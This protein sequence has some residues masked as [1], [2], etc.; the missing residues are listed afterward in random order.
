MKLVNQQNVGSL[1]NIEEREVHIIKFEGSNDKPKVLARMYGSASDRRGLGD[2]V[3][4]N[5]VLKHIKHYHPDWEVYVE[6]SRGKDSCHTGFCK[7][8]FCVEDRNTPVFDT[9][10]N[11]PFEEPN[12]QT[13]D[14]SLEHNVPAS[15]PTSA[16]KKVL[17]Q[18]PIKE[19]FKYQIN[20][21]EN[22][23]RRARKYMES[24][25]QKN[26]IVILHYQACSS[27]NNK[28][29]D[30]HDAERICKSLL[31]NGYTP[32]IF[33]WFG[34]SPLPDNKKIFCPSKGHP[35]WGE[36]KNNGEAKM[37]AALIEQARLFVGV[38]SGPLHVAGCCQTP[39]IG[40]WKYHHPA[41]YYDLTDNVT[42]L[43][44]GDNRKHLR[45]QKS[46]HRS[47]VQ[48]FFENNYK[49]HYYHNGRGDAVIDAICREL[50]VERDGPGSG[51]NG[52]VPTH[53]PYGNFDYVPP[54][55]KNQWW[56]IKL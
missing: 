37:I 5:I 40:F 30:P 48:E 33:D 26:G 15:K 29:I 56:S 2:A 3:Q 21:D 43:I 24:L 45:S 8:T 34:T 14:W 25:P 46:S 42:H 51:V 36:H 7:R 39:A 13:C 49:H 11:F 9:I 52:G 31:V 55:Q 6:S 41:H 47:K 16:I 54:V 53:I 35:V 23:R 38:D 19:Y 28:N 1:I 17:N 22:T 27:P 18:I 10:L 20:I 44:S 4:F 12:T 50:A 32:L